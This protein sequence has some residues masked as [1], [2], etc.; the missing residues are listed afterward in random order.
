MRGG[1]ERRR[2]K[3]LLPDSPIHTE[4]LRQTNAEVDYSAV[5]VLSRDFPL[6]SLD[7]HI[8]VQ[9][10]GAESQ[11]AGFRL[12]AGQAVGLDPDRCAQGVPTTTVDARITDIHAENFI[13]TADKPITGVLEARAVLTG[14]GK[15]VHAAASNAGGTFTAVVPKGGMRHSL[16]EWTG[17]DVLPALGLSLAGDNSNTNLRCAVASFSAKNGVMASQSFVIDTDPVRVDGAGHINLADETLSLQLQG[18]PKSFQL[19]RLRAPITL[20]GPWAHP[21]VGLKAGPALAQGGI[22]AA[23]GFL[24]PL[25]SVL[26]FIDP[27]LA[28]DANCGPLLQQAKAQ[29]NPVKSAS[30][31]NAPAPRK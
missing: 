3:Y 11:A 2:S 14:T 23:L 7:T 13:K 6:T 22:A 18:K 24:N 5:S 25:A 4:R 19:V 12:H 28:K 27:G 21:V 29:G 15:S 30:I 1:K 31:A 17:V 9:N 20:T 26:A 8:S 10:G 16:A